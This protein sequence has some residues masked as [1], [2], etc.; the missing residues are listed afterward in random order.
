MHAVLT[1]GGGLKMVLLACCGIFSQL[2]RTDGEPSVNMFRS[3]AHAK[4]GR[5][6]RLS[7]RTILHS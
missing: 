2:H 6:Q 1:C 7:E 5:C 4:N 3:V